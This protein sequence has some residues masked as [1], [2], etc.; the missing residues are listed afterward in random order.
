MRLSRRL[1]DR[2][3]GHLPSAALKDLFEF[4]PIIEV[5][6]LLY[7]VIKACWTED[8]LRG[9]VLFFFQLQLKLAPIVEEIS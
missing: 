2:F 7:F 8:L 5:V 9:K 1:N 3:C 6:Q 4:L